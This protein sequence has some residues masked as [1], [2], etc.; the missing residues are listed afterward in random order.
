MI[1]NPLAVQVLGGQ[2]AEGDH[3]VVESDGE[4]FS[5]RKEAPA[6]VAS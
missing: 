3:I 2:F 5:F 1:E 4:T 6:A